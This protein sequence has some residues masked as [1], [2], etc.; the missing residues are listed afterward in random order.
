MTHSGPSR[1]RLR[2]SES[3]L[4]IANGNPLS[5]RADGIAQAA[6]QQLTLRSGSHVH[7]VMS[8]HAGH[9]RAVAERWAT[10]HLDATIIGIGG[11]GTLNEIAN[12]IL[13]ATAACGSR[14]VLV[15]CPAGDANDQY[16]SWPRSR[17][18]RLENVLS[19]A[20]VPVD[21][22][23]MSYR[24]G[25][26]A[27]ATQYA[28]SYAAIGA[29][30]TGASLV[31][32]RR[33]RML[34]NLTVVPLTLFRIRPITVVVDGEAT[35]L[36]SL[37]W[38]VVPTMAKVL[39]VSTNSRRDD[40][41]MEVLAVPHPP[42]LGWLRMIW[43]GLRALVGLGK[44]SQR[45]R[46]TVHWEDGGAAQLDGETIDI[47]PGSDLNVRCVPAALRVLCCLKVAPRE[48]AVVHRTG[49]RRNSI[50]SSVRPSRADMHSGRPARGRAPRSSKRC[51]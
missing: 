30:A 32:R 38:H 2:T 47:P 29:L 20:P 24:T 26:G 25:G 23:E 21:V 19:A 4:I 41:L 7:L 11:D 17:R 45:A 13:A 48:H 35:C 42:E 33:R 44:Q 15:I 14:A 34:T 28:L 31:N 18:I 3:I 37:S 16:R 6:L 22:L 51:G 9:A 49:Q 27:Q 10:E 12:G 40:G 39:R 5:R 46:M 1:D 43:L 8:E 50:G 36:D